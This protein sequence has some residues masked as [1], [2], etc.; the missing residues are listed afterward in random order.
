MEVIYKIPTY[1]NIQ[2]TCI[3]VQIITLLSSTD[4]EL[5]GNCVIHIGTTSGYSVVY[6]IVGFLDQL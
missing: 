3:R 5:Q 6:D 2:K 4:L 1:I